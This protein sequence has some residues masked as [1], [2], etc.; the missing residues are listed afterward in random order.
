MG[1]Q[2][3]P[4]SVAL[5]ARWADEYNTLFS[6]PDVCRKRRRTLERAFEKAGRSDLHLSLMTGCIVGEGPRDVERRVR[7]VMQRSG[8]DG[9]VLAWVGA[10]ASEWV[11]G[12]VGEVV[13][14]LGEFEEAGVERVMLQHLCHDDLDMVRLLGSE[15]VPRV[16]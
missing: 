10:H 1:G 4:K 2:A 8:Q 13:D 7:N 11:I 15:V 6:T 9:D 3:G 14:R 16:A 12:T 5:A